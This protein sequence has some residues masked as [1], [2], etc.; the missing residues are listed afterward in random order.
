MSAVLEKNRYTA[1][2]YLTLEPTRLVKA[3]ST[4]VK[5]LP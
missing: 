3:N 2:G 1:E 4:T 5:S